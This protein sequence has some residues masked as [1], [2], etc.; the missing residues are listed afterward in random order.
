MNC[1]GQQKMMRIETRDQ[2]L[3]AVRAM[4]PCRAKTGSAVAVLGWIALVERVIAAEA[5]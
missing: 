2:M 1:G 4:N 5:H 3:V